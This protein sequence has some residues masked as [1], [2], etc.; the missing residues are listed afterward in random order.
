MQG[1]YH[2]WN[3]TSI[4]PLQRAVKTGS[5]ETFKEF[6][7]HFD[8]QSARFATLRGLFDFEENPIPLDEVE[9]AAEIVK[10]FTTGAMSLGSLSGRRTRPWPSR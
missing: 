5:F 9:P 10:R 7:R 6:T 2:Q 3:Q 1:Q 4:P 8:E